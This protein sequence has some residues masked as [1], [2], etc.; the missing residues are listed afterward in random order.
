MAGA[1]SESLGALQQST[2]ESSMR[3]RFGEKF[4][5]AL[6]PAVLLLLLELLLGERR[7]RREVV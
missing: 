5:Y 6:L 4:Q 7:R 1:L 2:I 3:H